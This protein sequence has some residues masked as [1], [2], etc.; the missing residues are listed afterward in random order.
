MQTS[1]AAFST[2][3][4]ALP[5]ANRCQDCIVRQGSIRS[6]GGK[7]KVQCFGSLKDVREGCP[8]YSDGKELEYMAS[9]APP[10]DFVPKKWAGGRA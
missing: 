10:K 4:T 8:S 5:C 3:Q 1:L 6:I 9:F 7:L 2:P